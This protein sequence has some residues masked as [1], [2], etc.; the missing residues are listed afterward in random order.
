MSVLADQSTD[1][2]HVRGIADEAQGNPVHP[3]FK[4]KGKVNLVL[5]RQGPNGQLHIREIH[6]LVVG[7][8]TTH[9][10]RAMQ[11]LIRLVNLLHFH[12][13][14]A[15][16]QKDPA[17]S[18]HLIRQLV[19]GD[20]GNG[21]VAA[22]RTRGQR[23][24]VPVGQGDRPIGKASESDL[25]TLQI[26]KDPNIDPNL[27]R[28]LPDG[29]DAGGVFAVIAVRKVQAERRRSGLDQFLDPLRTFR[30]RANGGHDLGPSV[31]IELAH[32]EAETPRGNYHP[33][34]CRPCPWSST[35]IRPRPAAQL[36][37]PRLVRIRFIR[38]LAW[39]VKP[40]RWP[41]R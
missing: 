28:H 20:R 31:L 17:A 30:G 12:L 41:T 9:R 27:L 6:A 24:T 7:E 8:D 36:P 22:H 26:L 29:G 13:N 2:L 18:G 32:I 39:P 14:T 40:E 16:I 15:V 11:G 25:W 5:V 21:L 23:E 33:G 4:A 3:L 10:D 35:P 1:L 19:V 34:V 38:R 37:I